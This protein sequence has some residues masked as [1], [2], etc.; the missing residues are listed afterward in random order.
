MTMRAVD[1]KSPRP[2]WAVIATLG[3]SL[4]RITELL[5]VERKLDSAHTGPH[6]GKV[7]L[8]VVVW[9]A[10]G[11]SERVCEVH[12]SKENKK[13]PKT[14]RTICCS[15][16]CSLSPSPRALTLDKRRLQELKMLSILAINARSH[17]A[18]IQSISRRATSESE[19]PGH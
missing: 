15:A 12:L 14:T 1:E 11:G 4:Q 18:S 2:S 8:A 6:A 17:V 13:P 16:I 5:S 3:Y 7:L 19:W 10:E 9:G